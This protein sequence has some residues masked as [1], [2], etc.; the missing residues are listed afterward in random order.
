[1][2]DDPPTTHPPEPKKFLADIHQINVSGSRQQYVP[3]TTTRKKIHEWVPPKA[4]AQWA[5]T[6]YLYIMVSCR[7]IHRVQNK[8][9]ILTF[10]K[11][12]SFNETWCVLVWAPESDRWV[13]SFMLCTQTLF[14]PTYF[15]ILVENRK[16]PKMQNMSG[17]ILSKCVK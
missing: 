11:S 7:C 14:L 4:E 16:F 17:W 15:E 13:F 1:M 10:M 2:T 5:L 9:S 8:I 12:Q 3:C 6:A